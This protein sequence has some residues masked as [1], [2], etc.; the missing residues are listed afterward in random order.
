MKFSKKK[1]LTFSVYF[2]IL[3][4]SFIISP[5]SGQIPVNFPEMIEPNTFV[6]ED[7]YDDWLYYMNYPGEDYSNLGIV[8]NGIS[9]YQNGEYTYFSSYDQ[10]AY[11]AVDLTRG[12]TISNNLLRENLRSSGHP[13]FEPESYPRAVRIPSTFSPVFETSST[14]EAI[15]LHMDHSYSFMADGYTNYFGFLNTSQSF[16]LDIEIFDGSAEGVIIFPDAHPRSGYSIGYI[17]KRMTYAFIPKNNLTMPLNFTLWLDTGSLVT[18][19]PHPWEFPT[20]I[21]QVAVNTTYSGN[22]DQGTRQRVVSNEIIYPENEIFSIR[23]FNLSLIAN[24]SY[25]IFVD[26]SM[27]ESSG[28]TSGQPYPFLISDYA[29]IL[30]GGLDQNGYE[31]YSPRN[32]SVILVFFAQGWSVGEYTIFYQNIATEAD[33]FI[34]GAELEFDKSFS[35]PG[36]NVYYTFTLDS[37]H[38]IALNYSNSNWFYFYLYVPGS[39]PN[40][41]EI[42]SDRYFFDPEA[43]NLYGDFAGDI[44]N[45]WRYFPAGTY[46]IRFSYYLSS[47]MFRFTKIPVMTP[48]TVSVT[49]DSIYAFEIPLTKNRI[50]FVNISTNDQTIPNQQ[51]QYEY[52]WVGKFNE[53]IRYVYNPSSTWIGNRNI[54]SQWIGWNSNNTAIESFLPAR[55]NEQPILIIRPYDAQNSTND[56][57]DP[58]S[59]ELTVTTN[60][61]LIQ[62]D[63]YYG[64]NYIGGGYFIPQN[65]IYSTTSFPVNNDTV[66]NTDHIYGIPLSLAEYRIYNITAILHG[67]YTSGPSS[68]NATI[69][70]FNI[71]GGNLAS[72]EIF[73]TESS[74]WDSTRYWSTMLIQTVSSTSYLY[75]D[76]SRTWDGSRYRN[77]VLEVRIE[78]VSNNYLYFNIPPYQ[79][80]SMPLSTEILHTQ[81]LAAQII[82]SEMIARG[83]PGFELL[84]SM[85]ALV[86]F[87]AVIIQSRRLKH[88]N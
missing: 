6:P 81:L 52:G 31:V 48:S 88:R 42:V 1:M 21:P 35:N 12:S 23:M 59:A 18:L 5:T 75:V 56:F 30:G 61:A 15:S 53:M 41:W 24:H 87:T 22:I 66:A 29:E 67:N 51:V 60:V 25:R 57:P 46:A 17:E 54:S 85:G 10:F 38:M 40:E 26:F 68:W 34:D 45:N 76:V 71:L 28:F 43:G 70:A 13:L 49:R 63:S 7:I 62:H 77:A 14:H 72:L 78:L 65:A 36:Y 2:T 3:L 11:T 8:Y 19:T 55:D 44:G 69:D 73:N 47:H 9:G 84:L 74:G 16:F 39:E 79:Y 27:L 32:E 82:A 20:Y 80:G 64:W 86:A 33:E 58:F 50:N 37:P 4:T 83:T